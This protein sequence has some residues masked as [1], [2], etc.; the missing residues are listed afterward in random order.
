MKDVNGIEIDHLLTEVNSVEQNFQLWSRYDWSNKGLEWCVSE[1][2]V[3]SIVRHVILKYFRKRAHLL[4]IGPGAGTWSLILADLAERI[5]LVDIVPKCLEMCR[6]Q[7][8]DTAVTYLLNDGVTLKE[9][10]D[11]DVDGIWSMNTFVHINEQDMLSY[12]SEFYRVLTPGGTAIIHHSRNGNTG[13]PL[14]W[15]SEM[16]D[17]KVATLCSKTGL[18]LVKQFRSW[19][20]EGQY[21]LWPKLSE[22]ECV[23]SISIIRKTL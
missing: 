10:A 6:E 9:V 16:T 21:R 4:E 15:R 13:I 23:D 17:E 11:N 22:E 2:W 18:E 7:L 5:T 19:G 3:K 8:G 12:F 1:D 20:K 14:G